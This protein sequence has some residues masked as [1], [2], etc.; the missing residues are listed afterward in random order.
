MAKRISGS[1]AT[2]AKGMLL[3]EHTQHSV[4]P[5]ILT[6]NIVTQCHTNYCC[7]ATPNT[8]TVKV[9]DDYTSCI[10]TA[11]K[12]WAATV[13]AVSCHILSHTAQPTV[14]T[15]SHQILSNV[16]LN[17]FTHRHPTYHD[18]CHRM[19]TLVTKVMV[20]MYSTG[21]GMHKNF[22]DLSVVYRTY[23]LS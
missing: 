16:T 21:A 20:R 23:H 11:E 9:F 6:S 2:V 19:S 14:I 18:Y 4:I 1:L 8:V 12:Q 5:N 22:S 15:V 7:S 3:L 13:V 10:P 17:T